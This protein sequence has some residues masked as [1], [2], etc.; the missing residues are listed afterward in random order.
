MLLSSSVPSVLISAL[1]FVL[2]TSE[3]RL[4]TP[5]VLQKGVI[6]PDLQVTKIY[7][8]EHVEKLKQEF[9]SVKSMGGATVE[10]WLK[11]LELRGKELLSDS[12]RWE[13]WSSTGGVAQLTQDSVPNTNISSG[14]GLVLM[15]G[16]SS[17]PK[18]HTNSSSLSG[19]LCR[20]TPSSAV[21]CGAAHGALI[22]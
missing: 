21:T 3:M 11:G 15:N 18:L 7:P 4:I 19:C 6:P 12:M 20:S 1:P 13:K 17:A 5:D 22:F 16:I 2:T 14:K 8:S 9:L 10:E